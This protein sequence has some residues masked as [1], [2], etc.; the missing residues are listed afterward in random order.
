[1]LRITIGAL[2]LSTAALEAQEQTW[3]CQYTE[4][5]GFG[6][7]EGTYQ[8]SKFNPDRPFFLKTEG[9]ELTTDS[10][11]DFFGLVA[12][13]H[14]HP[15]FR[16]E[17]GEKA[18]FQTRSTPHGS[19]IVFGASTGRGAASE[20]LGSVMT[21]AIRDSIAVKLFVCQAM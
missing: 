7:K 2:L 17:E 16:I 14:C 11:Q 5:V 19:S 10:A 8:P 6:F 20:I 1:M 13:V 18:L 21:G 9:G 15:G 12:D 3:A 4:A